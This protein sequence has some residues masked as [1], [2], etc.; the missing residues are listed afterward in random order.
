MSPTPDQAENPKGRLGSKAALRT[1]NW[2]EV[3]SFVTSTWAVPHSVITN[4]RCL[5]ALA[6]V[7]LVVAPKVMTPVG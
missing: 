4:S 2:R 7:T 5:S 1:S 6:V 3:T